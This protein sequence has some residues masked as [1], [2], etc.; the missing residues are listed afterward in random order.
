MARSSGLRRRLAVALVAVA[1]LGD[2]AVGV[3][4]LTSAVA[5]GRA[6]TV[7]QHAAATARVAAEHAARGAAPGLQDPEPA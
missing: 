7:A 4:A 5:A 3:T 6:H 1:V 2:A